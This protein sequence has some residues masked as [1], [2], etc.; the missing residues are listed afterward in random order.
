MSVSGET[1]L[2]MTPMIPIV[3]IEEVDGGVPLAEAL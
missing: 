2:E 3:E 1:L